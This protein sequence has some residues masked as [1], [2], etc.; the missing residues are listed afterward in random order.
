MHMQKL[1]SLFSFLFLLLLTL[2]TQPVLGQC[3]PEPEPSSNC[4]NAPF[5]CLQDVC[6]STQNV[7][8]S[9][10]QGWCGNN[11]I[12]NNPHYVAFVAEC[13][14]ILL[15]IYVQSCSGQ[16]LQ[17]GIIAN[18]PWSGA[19]DV[20]ACNAGTGQ[21]GTIV[22]AATVTVGSVY[23]L[24]I[25]GSNGAICQYTIEEADC[26]Q[27]P[28]LDGDLDE[29]EA[30]PEE[31]CQGY[32]SLTITLGPV[33]GNAHG[34]YY[35]FSWDTDDTLTT[36]DPELVF[37]VPDDV[38]PGTYEV[39]ARAFSGCDTMDFEIC[40]E[41]EV[42]EIPPSEKDPETFCPEE[43]PFSWHGVNIGG[44]GEYTASFTDA[45]GC[46]YD[47]TWIVEEYPEVPLGI[48]DTVHCLP[49]GEESFIYEGEEYDAPGTYEL[50]YL[51]QGLNG[52]DSFAELNL[53]MIGITA[54]VEL[55]CEN[56]DFVLTAITEDKYP[57]NADVTFNW[58]ESGNVVSDDVEYITNLD[59]TYDLIAIVTT[60]GGESCEFFIES[61]SFDG[62]SLKPDAP[63]FAFQTVS[64][65]AEAGFEFS[66]IVDPFEDPLEYVWT[67]PPGAV[68]EQDGSE[69]VTID[70]T[71]S[72]GGEVCAFAINECGEGETACFN[73]DILP[74]P[75]ADFTIPAA[76]CIDQVVTATFTGDASPNAEINWDFDS[77]SS[78]TGSG[79]G[80]YQVAWNIPGLK[81]VTL[82]VI[83][84]GCDTSELTLTVDVTN[85][86]APVINCTSTLT[87]I[88]FDW[89]D[90]VGANCY[91]VVINGQLPAINTCNS[92]Y[93]V[94]GLN[95][96]DEV[97]IQLTVISAGACPNVMVTDMCTAEDCPGVPIELFGP[98]TV[99]L[100]NPANITYTANVNGAPGTGVW[101]GPGIIDGPNGIF[102]PPTAGAGQHT[103]T[104]TTI[105]AGCDHE[106][107]MTVTVF[108]SLT[109]DFTV[110]NA[111]CVTGTSTVTYTGNASGGANYQWDFGTATVVSGSGA[112]PYELSWTTAGT[113]TIRLQVSENTCSS[114]LV[115]RTVEVSP[116]LTAPSVGCA[117]TPF[118]VT[119]TWTI[120]GNASGHAVNPLS[121][122]VGTINGNMY[123]FPNLVAGDSV[124]IEIVTESMGP[125][126]ERRDTF[127]CVAKEC[128]TPGFN[129]TPV[130]P[131]CLYPG[132]STIQLEVEV[133]NGTGTGSWS[134][135]GV[136][137]SGLF[138]PVA[139]GAGSHI[140]TYTYLD[141]ECTFNPNIT[142]QVNDVPEANITTTNLVITCATNSLQIDGSSSTGTGL[143]YSWSTD[144][145]VI[146]GAN[147]NPI[148]TVS[149]AGVYQLLVSTPAGC[150]DSTSV[151]VT[152]D[153]GIPTADAG[154]DQTLNCNVEVVTL[155]GQS[156]TGPNIEYTWTTP[157]GNI[158]GP[159]NTATIMVD[160][161]G[162]YNLMVMDPTTGCSNTDQ[163]VVDFDTAVATIVLTPGDTIDCNTTVS[164]IT[165]QLSE[166][167]S[168]YTFLWS[169]TDGVIS[170]GNTG[171]TLDVT[172]GGTYTLEVTETSTGCV[173][174][175]D[176]EV[177]ESD[178]IIDGLVSISNNIRCNGENNGSISIMSVDGGIAPYTYTW[179]PSGAGTDLTN[180]RP[181]T[182]TVTVADQNGCTFA[183]SF[184]I[185]E[186][187]A[188]TVDLGPNQTIAVDDSVSISIL[189]NL[190][191]DAIAQ[192]DWSS[193][194]GIFC[195]G[196]PIFEFIAAN[197][198]TISATVIDTA[199]CQGSDSMR[200]TVL[201]P[202]IIYVPNVFSPND[203]GV[204]DFFTIY[205][206]RNLTRILLLEI[207]DRWGNQV[208]RTEDIEPGV[209]S[210][211]WN[212][213]F[214]DQDMQSGVYVYV[215]KLRY[216]DGLDDEMISGDIT[217]VRQED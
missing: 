38:E 206:R 91:D 187:A 23:Y 48:L 170:G 190:S 85:L 42:Y 162:A 143:T 104:F 56:G 184:T 212:G 185:T 103:L 166:P 128:P 205:G 57:F 129:I 113:K 40:T 192:I 147:N 141:Q 153:A 114:E 66:V 32:N 102:N 123:F 80:P 196:C 159:S 110:D 21:G 14:N 72:L 160:L 133:T 131:I 164:T 9:C 92:M 155:G 97:T 43:F 34:Y 94:T 105:V 28:Q 217:I 55:T 20:I 74:T 199:G 45:D 30:S 83:E 29:I 53:V 115:V 132:T 180:L 148:V 37:D 76:A 82:Q 207:Y 137:P 75:D 120:D 213:K 51:G 116:A 152:L 70:F 198:Q 69:T 124:V 106:E 58:I 39:C 87:S 165:S 11:T 64:I 93:E 151:T 107:T 182:Y 173:A 52:C 145:G 47:S 126:P 215:A 19:P 204:N 96:G 194:N 201:V 117:P 111:I 67:G 59:G 27:Q 169:T 209:P 197:S 68:V 24:L 6:Y 95:P 135:T 167:G 193:Y 200:L 214:N 125:C 101:S 140:A 171:Q 73:V 71:Y 178:E 1:V 25:D 18:C 210:L 157:D 177:A 63:E 186:P 77:P 8:F 130:D 84:P 127:S 7:P 22:M 138:D 174:T 183:Q 81:N 13:E 191:D 203:D 175:G 176:V 163:A 172:Q 78:L 168:G 98:D 36:T 86:V 161:D 100:N 108:D 142:I 112:G 26:I 49:T 90:V 65:C 2:W 188:V 181:G 50:E 44:P 61:F 99:C 144:D 109:A 122:H 41:F 60:L 88:T 17:A 156:S 211:G 154:P 158:I 118:D 3:D 12:I 208:F 179:S 31:V 62:E 46:F 134:G 189:T 4:A 121:G 216:E 150:K 119:F 10:C 149:N 202:R 89:D 33:V 79:E 35:V 16:G 146:S 139:A 15:E 136:S 54:Y 5:T 195:P